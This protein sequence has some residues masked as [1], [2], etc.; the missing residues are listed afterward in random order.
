MLD[1]LIFKNKHICHAQKKSCE[2]ERLNHLFILSLSK[3]NIID[4]YYSS[5]MLD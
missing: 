3:E 5:S 2:G 1:V 4:T